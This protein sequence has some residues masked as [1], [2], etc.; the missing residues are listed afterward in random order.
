MIFELVGV[1]DIHYLVADIVGCLYDVYK[2]MP[3]KA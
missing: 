3:G 2:R 1:F